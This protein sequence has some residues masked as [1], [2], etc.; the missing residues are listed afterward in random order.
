MEA[1]AK[2]TLLLDGKCVTRDVWLLAGDQ[3]AAI[4]SH[5]YTDGSAFVDTIQLRSIVQAHRAALR[6][7]VI[8]LDMDEATFRDEVLIDF[9]PLE[10]SKDASKD[11]LAP[12]GE[13]SSDSSSK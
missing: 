8:P 10:E 2:L 1:N 7:K 6:A 3:V 5:P 11:D 9:E 12:L 13:Q 4:K